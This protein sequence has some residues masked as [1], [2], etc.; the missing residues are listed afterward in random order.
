MQKPQNAT[1]ERDFLV[2]LRSIERRAI[3]PLKWSIYLTAVFFWAMSR[4]ADWPPT[5]DGLSSLAIFFP[6]DVFAFFTIFFMFNVGETYFLLL[7]RVA[8]SQT[9]IL[10][11]ISYIADLLFIT[12]LIYLDMKRHPQPQAATDFYIFYVLLILRGF[13]LFRTTRANLMANAAVGAMFVITLLWQ[14]HSLSTYSSQNNLM[15]VVFV[16]LVIVMSWFIAEI[17]NRQK[18]ELLRTQQRLMQSENMAAVGELAAGVAHEINNPIGIISAY[19]E[20]LEKNTPETDPRREDFQTIHK[21][22]RRCERIVKQLL[23]YA[24]PG[25][26]T[27][28][29]V[30]LKTL[31]DEVLNLVNWPASSADAPPVKIV[32]QYADAVPALLMDENQIK[33]ALLNLYLNALQAMPSGG[34]LTI[35]VDPD[36]ERNSVRLK[37]TDTGKGISPDDLK[38]IF[39]P[40]FTTRPEGTGLGL[41]ITRR[42]LE[43][44]GAAVEVDSVADHGTTLQIYFPM[45]HSAG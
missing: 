10:C 15:R 22:A 23:T 21:E 24:R 17:I 45:D 20:F 26:G 7:S 31:N 9:R 1:E 13:A 33:Q 6:V 14:D 16:G 11:I 37:I 43:N 32:R 42:I 12:T 35:A 29:S 5:G 30:D 40:F 2:W 27:M 41:A 38:R 44:H 18:D 4:A 36:Y 28:A 39:D 34:T 19:A 8:I 25:T 3:L